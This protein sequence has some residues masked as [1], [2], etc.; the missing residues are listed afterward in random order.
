[1]TENR[2][3]NYRS[4]QQ[5]LNHCIDDIESL[6]LRTK[7]SAEAWKK[8]QKK[9]GKDKS[10]S[11]SCFNPFPNWNEFIWMLVLRWTNRKPYARG[12]ST[13]STGRLS[14]CVSKVEACLKLAGEFH[15]GYHK[16]LSPPH[17]SRFFCL[18]TKKI[19]TCHRLVFS[20]FIQ[21]YNKIGTCRAISDRAK[22]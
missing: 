22:S 10:K 15:F 20:E 21:I 9:K 3:N 16:H 19:F 11:V 8:W 17:N 5:I 14:W 1:M 18:P 12:S 13:T 6:V 4:F 7:K 2:M